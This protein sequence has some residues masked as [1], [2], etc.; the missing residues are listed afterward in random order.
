MEVKIK[1]LDKTLPLPVYE[2][3]GSVGFDIIARENI[4]I[5]PKEISLIPS[6]LIVEVPKGYMLVVASRSSTPMKK[7]LTPPHG[8][9]IIDHDYCGPDDEIKVLVYNFKDVPAKV[10]RGEKIAQGVFV[11]IDKFE[12]EEVDDINK[13]SRGGFGSTGGY[14]PASGGI[15]N[16]QL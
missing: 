5:P 13:N 3:D 12:W 16:K 8:F 1:R 11:K 6:N 4:E 15:I 2:T 9:G 7:G 14:N 10:M